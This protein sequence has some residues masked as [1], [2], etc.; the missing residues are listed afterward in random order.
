[1]RPLKSST[2]G[3]DAAVEARDA[4]LVGGVVV[5]RPLQPDVGSV[6]PI[7]NLQ[8]GVRGRANSPS[9][10]GKYALPVKRVST[11]AAARLN[12]LWPEVKAA[13][14]GVTKV[15][16]WYGTQFDGAHPARRRL[17]CVVGSAG[18][19]GQA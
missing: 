13:N 12:V 17:Y 9:P 3:V 6:G 16:R 18:S 15:L 11:S 1:M 5:A 2:R 8:E 7:S 19:P 4:G 10:P 14:G